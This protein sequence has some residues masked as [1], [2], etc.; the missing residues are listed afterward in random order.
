V[1]DAIVASVK[2]AA[3]LAIVGGLMWLAFFPH[4]ILGND[5]RLMRGM[6][7]FGAI[8]AVVYV[9]ESKERGK[10]SADIQSERKVRE[11]L[12][13][14]ETGGFLPKLTAEELRSLADLLVKKADLISRSKSDTRDRSAN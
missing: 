8:L 13:M 5:D 3:L 12:A 1:T 7:A 9:S 6:C 4:D 2:L 11:C 10:S 14:Y